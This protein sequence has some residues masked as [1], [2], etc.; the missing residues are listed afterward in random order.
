M[1]Q[2]IAATYIQYNTEFAAILLQL[3]YCRM[4][5]V[6]YGIH[7]QKISK[8]H[9]KNVSCLFIDVRVVQESIAISN[10]ETSWLSQFFHIRFLDEG[11]TGPKRPWTILELTS[12]MKHLSR[13]YPGIRRISF[14]EIARREST[15]K[16]HRSLCTLASSTTVCLTSVDFVIIVHHYRAHSVCM[17]LRPSFSHARLCDIH[18][19][20]HPQIWNLKNC[21]V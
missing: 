2:R 20:L 19:C 8:R 18:S 3:L 11:G 9:R 1:L 21:E 17:S 5:S 7:F 10:H 12:M 6:L 14:G 15:R 16:R 13:Q 4:A